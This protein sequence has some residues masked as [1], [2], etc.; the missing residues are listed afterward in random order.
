MAE[1]GVDTVDCGNSTS[2]CKTLK[3]VHGLFIRSCNFVIN[4]STRINPKSLVRIPTQGRLRIFVILNVCWCDLFCSYAL[5]LPGTTK[6]IKVVGSLTGSSEDD[7]EDVSDDSP[8]DDAPGDD[9]PVDD[10]AQTNVSINVPSFTVS[11]SSAHVYTTIL[12]F[13]GVSPTPNSPFT[14]PI[15]KFENDDTLHLNASELASVTFSD[16]WLTTDFFVNCHSNDFRFKVENVDFASTESDKN[17]E[18]KMKDCAS[19]EGLVLDSKFTNAL[20]RLWAKDSSSLKFHNTDI[21][22]ETSLFQTRP[23]ASTGLKILYPSRDCKHDLQV[24][25]CT[26]TGNQQNFGTDHPQGA[27]TVETSKASAEVTIRVKNTTFSDNSRGMDLSIKGASEIDIV[28]CVFEGNVADGSGGGARFTPTLQAGLSS[29]TDVGATH[30]TL[31]ETKFINNVAL[32]SSQYNETSVFY[33]TRSPGSGG[34]MYIFLTAFSNLHHYGL[35]SIE[36]CSF[37]NNTASIQGG[38]F[39]VNPGISLQLI[40]T[41]ISSADGA[42]VRRPKLGD[43]IFATNNMT[44]QNVDFKVIGSTNV[45]L[46]S[47]QAS[48][49]SNSRLLLDNVDVTCPQAHQIDIVNT[50]S[51]AVKGGIETLTI[52][53]L[54]CADDY[55]SLSRTRG[56][57]NGVVTEI[58]D[59]VDCTRCPYGAKCSKGIANTAGFWG[60][61]DSEGDVSMYLCPPDYCEPSATQGV[62]YD[63]CAVNRKGVL[64]GRCANGYSESLFGSTCILNKE[65]G[66]KNWYIGLLVAVYG[67]CYVLFFMF[68]KDWARFMHYLTKKFTCCSKKKNPNQPEERLDITE[69]GYFQIFMYF[70]Q[71]SALLKVTIILENDDIYSS[72]HRPQ[73]LLPDFLID[74]VK[75]LL[76]LNSLKFDA[77]TC[78]FEDTTPVMKV[79]INSIFILYLFGFLFLV[80][81]CSGLCCIWMPSKEKP[82]IGVMGMNARM[83]ATVV[84]LFLYTYQAVAENAFMLL[85]CASVNGNRVLFFDGTISCLQDWQWGVIALV[86][87]FVIP[88]FATLLF[89]PK[90]LEKRYIS[91]GVLFVAFLFPLFAAVPFI[92][93]Y[94]GCICRKPKTDQSSRRQ[95]ANRA[96]MLRRRESILSSRD[97]NDKEDL[98]DTIVDVI[99]GPYRHDVI[100]GVCWEGVINFRRMVLVIMFTFINDKL[101]KQMA[102]SFTCFAILMFHIFSRPFKQKLSNVA[103]T[104]SLSL[105]LVISGTNLVK[106]AFFHSQ[107]IPRG[108]NYLVMIIYE[109][110]EAVCIGILPLCI[111]ALLIL[112]VTIKGSAVLIQKGSKKKKHPDPLDDFEDD[113]PPYIHDPRMMM[114]NGHGGHGPGF[115]PYSSGPPPRM[116]KRPQHERNDYV[117]PRLS[118]N[119]NGSPMMGAYGGLQ[120]LGDSRYSNSPPTSSHERSHSPRPDH[121]RRHIAPTGAVYGGFNSRPHSFTDDRLRVPHDNRPVRSPQRSLHDGPVRQRARSR[122]LSPPRWG[123]SRPSNHTDH[124]TRY[125]F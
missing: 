63:S 6:H 52:F 43:V 101:L 39:F 7:D 34:A 94:F 97:D 113:S 120:Y 25:N 31:T 22:A 64:C 9:T 56:L 48:D 5:Q 8:D 67:I 14:K 23:D 117:T 125:P 12:T 65:C 26:F 35:I 109:W 44:I 122:S 40:N 58:F 96:R 105:L 10:T 4:V 114:A 110:I 19:L 20:I 88:F 121:G 85:N 3:Y 57:I 83:L 61:P 103:E 81:L 92:L 18:M 45:P 51:Y 17:I 55:Y 15:I 84:S 99:A 38:T 27:L 53:C 123:R 72:V 69:T 42:T 104:V 11:L 98:A 90:L 47:Y 13:Q 124:L 59:Q 77:R 91:L 60:R 30:I 82:R 93:M 108:E 106:A 32:T 70:I 76:S 95:R 116:R 102:L 29:T 54:V 87:I 37:E 36:F 33:Q 1:T 2:P 71:T 50:S 75:E 80:Y 16:V 79:V 107:T 21:V 89:G 86:C 111:L 74:G 24:E 46:L 62:V 78:L 112:T 66:E 115:P 100:G 49:P 68:E 118:R 119:L 73:D 28:Q 41:T